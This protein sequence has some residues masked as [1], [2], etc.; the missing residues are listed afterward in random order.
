MTLKGPIQPGPSCGSVVLSVRGKREVLE[1]LVP[2]LAFPGRRWSHPLGF[3]G[4]RCCLM[5]VHHLLR[6][7][8]APGSRKG[9]PWMMR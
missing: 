7:P 3:W 5:W 8:P 1:E 9:F 4:R 6:H 2:L